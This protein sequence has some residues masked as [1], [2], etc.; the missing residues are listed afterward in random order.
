MVRYSIVER[1]TEV[2]VKMYFF[3]GIELNV[4]LSS[5]STTVVEEADTGMIHWP[6]VIVGSLSIFAS[7]LLAFL[8][9]LPFK[10]PVASSEVSDS[11]IQLKKSAKT[12]I[13]DKCKKATDISE[14][15]T[16]ESV[17]PEINF[18]AYSVF[19]VIIFFY[20]V[21]TCG[22]ERIFQPMAYSFGLCGPLKLSPGRAVLTDTCYNGGFMTGRILSIF[23]GLI[24]E[25]AFLC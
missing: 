24:F 8:L 1:T 25:F 10:I 21:I 14:I 9:I 12:D 17:L 2:E 3:V 7:V 11:A 19:I 16:S 18:K 20:Y 6:F 23:I 15:E 13:Q 4:T 5:E 22:I